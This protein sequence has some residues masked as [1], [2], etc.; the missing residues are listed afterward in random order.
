M[1]KEQIESKHLHEETFGF[2]NMSKPFVG[3][4]DGITHDEPL[5]DAEESLSDGSSS[6]HSAFSMSFSS[7]F[8]TQ[9]IQL[10]DP[11]LRN[12]RISTVNVLQDLCYEFVLKSTACAFQILFW[13]ISSYTCM[14]V[15][16]S[17]KT[18]QVVLLNLFRICDS[19]YSNRMRFAAHEARKLIYRRTSSSIH[20]IHS[21]FPETSNRGP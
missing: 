14:C 7:A 6:L 4:V 13:I 8:R 3:L 19:R 10:I 16:F 21:D 11:W 5:N 9:M 20:G 2:L 18:K 15:Q 12:D 1:K 17:S